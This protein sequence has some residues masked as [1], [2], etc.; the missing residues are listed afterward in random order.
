MM[1]KRDADGDLQFPIQSAPERYFYAGHLPK[2]H[3][4]LIGRDLYGKITVAIFDSNGVL[5][6]VIHKV[7]PSPPVIRSVNQIRDVDED[8]FQTYLQR[9]Y[10]FSSGEIHIKEFSVPKEMFAV[11]HLPSSYRVFLEDP[12]SP[13]LDDEMRQAFPELIRQWNELG[14]FVLEW[15]NDYWLNSTGQVIA[16]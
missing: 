5:I 4:A 6:D 2:R 12:N 8:D 9:E 16:S 13:I 15:G 11:Y 10:G 3:Q 14:Q 7:L 1:L